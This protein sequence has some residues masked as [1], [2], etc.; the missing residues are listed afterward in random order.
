TVC[1]LTG[2]PI[3]ESVES[4]SIADL[5][6]GASDVG[7]DSAFSVYRDIHRM[8]TDGEWKLVRHY[9]AESRDKGVD[10]VQLFHVA[11]DPWELND[12]SSDPAHGARLHALAA[13]MTA[14]MRDVGDPFASRPVL[15]PGSGG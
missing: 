15:L 4:R 5:A 14:W 8:V 6:T 11:E 2:T 1:D 3:P 10:R 13:T 12:L 9:R 7:R